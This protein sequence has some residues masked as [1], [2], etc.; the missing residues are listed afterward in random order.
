MEFVFKYFA[1][2]WDYLIK[3]FFSEKTHCPESH[4]FVYDYD[5]DE[6]AC[7]TEE[8]GDDGFGGDFCPGAYVYCDALPCQ[9]HP[10]TVEEEG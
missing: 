9:N 2:I 6:D 10:S 7:C 8:V 5:S 3:M 1:H 4:P